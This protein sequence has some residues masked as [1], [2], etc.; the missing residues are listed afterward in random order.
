MIPRIQS[1]KNTL[2]KSVKWSTSATSNAESI[3]I[4]APT[5]PVRLKS[6]MR[7]VP[8]GLPDHDTVNPEPKDIVASTGEMSEEKRKVEKDTNMVQR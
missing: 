4:V 1:R 6:F 5:S 7:M 2:V 3:S 8:R